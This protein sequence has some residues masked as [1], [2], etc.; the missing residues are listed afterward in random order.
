[1]RRPGDSGAIVR[2]SGVCGEFSM[3]TGDAGLSP[4]R[5]NTRSYKRNSKQFVCI[6]IF[7]FVHAQSRATVIRK[8]QAEEVLE[9][10][11]DP[12]FR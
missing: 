9:P 5:K 11:E 4:R 3:L 12:A 8:L 1:M 6:P 10:R 2:E 7:H